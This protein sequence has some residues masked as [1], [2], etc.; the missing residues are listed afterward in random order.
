MEHETEFWLTRLFNEY[1]GG[2]LSSFLTVIGH[3]PDNPAHPWENWIVIELLVVAV[4]MALFAFLRGRLSADKPG[5][6]QMTF[7][8][9]YTMV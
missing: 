8:A 9:L 3:P 6:L 4:I 2:P 5:K 1:L 7:E